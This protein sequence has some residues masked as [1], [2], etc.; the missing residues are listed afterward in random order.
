MSEQEHL[1]TCLGEE[2]I[3][4]A[5]EMA[6]IASKTNRF[7]LSDRSNLDPPG[8]TN[9]ERLVTELN[10]IVAVADMLA[11]AGVI[12]LAWFDVEVQRAKRERLQKWMEHSV[13]QN[14]LQTPA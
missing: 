3:E 10:E 7:G 12:P 2:G 14:A 6:K 5:L 11:V 13:A 8:P 4:V 1:I 9:V